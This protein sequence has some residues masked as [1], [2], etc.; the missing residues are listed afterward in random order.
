[1]SQQTKKE[2]YVDYLQLFRAIAVVF[3]VCTISLVYVS[4]YRHQPWTAEFK[5]NAQYQF[6]LA[7][8]DAQGKL[9]WGEEFEPQ[10]W[11]NHKVYIPIEKIEEQP[12][13][14]Q[15]KLDVLELNVISFELSVNTTNRSKRS[16]YT[17][18]LHY[19]LLN[20]NNR[21]QQQQEQQ[22]S[23][24]PSSDEEKDTYKILWDTFVFFINN[25]TPKIHLTE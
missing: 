4:Y 22:H 11:L 3:A 21:Q 13:L 25:F 7:T 1:V 16:F 8:K 17:K 15:L 14:Y 6:T 2:Y 12:G 19:V 5:M 23:L 18:P 9:G 10:V 20:S 24:Q